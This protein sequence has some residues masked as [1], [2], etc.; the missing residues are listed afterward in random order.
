[1]GILL[2]TSYFILRVY[3]KGLKLSGLYY[4]IDKSDILFNL[5]VFPH[6]VFHTFRRRAAYNFPYSYVSDV[7]FARY[8]KTRRGAC[9]MCGACC[10]GCSDLVVISDGKKI[11]SIYKRRDWCDV[12]FPATKQ[13][14][15]FVTKLHNLHCGFYFDDKKNDNISS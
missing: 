8:K 9:N 14:L 10:K 5:Y 13:Q 4:L 7:L 6:K 2:N 3:R 15:E 11:C 1:M 12:Y